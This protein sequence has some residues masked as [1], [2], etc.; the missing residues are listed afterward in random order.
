MD[1]SQCVYYACRTPANVVMATFGYL[2]RSSNLALLARPVLGASLIACRV[3][4]MSR[5][6]VRFVRVGLAP[7]VSANVGIA[8]DDAAQNRISSGYIAEESAR[9]GLMR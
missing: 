8:T 7:A 6:A 2:T 5:S 3:R 1:S 9:L 4:E